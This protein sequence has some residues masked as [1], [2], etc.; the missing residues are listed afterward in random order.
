MQFFAWSRQLP[1]ECLELKFPE[2]R[3]RHRLMWASLNKVSRRWG[4]VRKRGDCSNRGAFRA[5]RMASGYV[6]AKAVAVRNI[7][8]MD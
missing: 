2:S 8:Q 6:I 1:N 5:I 4:K 3:S 7:F